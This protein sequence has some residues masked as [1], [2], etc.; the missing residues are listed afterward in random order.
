MSKPPPCFK[1]ATPF[2]K[3]AEE[4]DQAASRPEAPLIAYYC[5]MYAM[6]VCM[7]LRNASTP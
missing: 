2:I 4:L 6:D 5:R 3:R 7:S 1:Q